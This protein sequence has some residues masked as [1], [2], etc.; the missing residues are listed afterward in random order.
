MTDQEYID[1]LKPDIRK[2]FLELSPEER[3]IVFN[4]FTSDYTKILQKI[5]GNT[6]FTQSKTSKGLGSR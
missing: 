2:R 4:N 5:L 3:N 1:A 6:L